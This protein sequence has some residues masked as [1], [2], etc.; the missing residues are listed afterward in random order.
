MQE[1][2][3]VFGGGPL[4]LSLIKRAQYQGY[5]AIVIDPDPNA[6][7]YSIADLFIQVAGNDFK[8]TMQIAIDNK[9]VGVVTTATDKPILMMCR[10]AKELN[11]PFPSYNSCEIVLNKS[12]FKQ[13]L[14]ENN[15]PHAK[16]KEYTGNINVSSINFCFPIIVK[17]IMN[18]GSRGVIKC[19]KRDDLHKAIEETLLH[20]DDKRF[21]IEEYIEGDE[22]S[23]EAIVQHNKVHLIQITDKIVTDPPY[24][25]ELAHIQPSKY[26]YLKPDIKKLLQTIV[27]KTGLNNCALHPEIKVNQNKLTIIEVGPRLGGDFITSHLVPLST[28][29]NIEDQLIN[30]SVGKPIHYKYKNKFAMVSYLNFP[31]TKK[32]LSSISENQLKEEFPNVEAFNFDLKVGAEINQI[33]NSLNRYGEFVISGENMQSLLIQKREILKFLE[34]H[35]YN[36]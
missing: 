24:N 29:I 13:F 6:V 31:P 8:K 35:I 3:L 23:I 9:V 22:I 36:H 7:C 33:S 12:K 26:E 20:C 16:G 4:Q 21:L 2:I 30:L 15:L 25:V 5:K 17:P 1:S 32:V 11:L 14:E 28:G 18:S 19:D 34:Y 10:I 27:D